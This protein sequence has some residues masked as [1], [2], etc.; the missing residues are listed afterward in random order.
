MWGRGEIETDEYVCVCVCVCVR[1]L[2]APAFLYVR[3]G[4]AAI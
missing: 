4:A 3:A 2:N 1:V